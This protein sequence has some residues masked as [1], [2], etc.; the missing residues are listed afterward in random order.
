MDPTIVQPFLDWGV[1]GAIIVVLG[2]AYWNQ[3]AKYEDVME[4]R[5][6]EGRESLD[7]INRNTSAITSLGDLIRATRGAS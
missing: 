2:W 3:K 7:A 1:P 5:L 6:A 4:K